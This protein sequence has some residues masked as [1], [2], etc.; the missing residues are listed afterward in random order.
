[1]DNMSSTDNCHDLW[2]QILT[3]IKAELSEQSF[4]TWFECVQC[5][6]YHDETIELAVPDKFYGEWLQ[7]HYREIIRSACYRVCNIKPEISYVVLPS[8]S[9]PVLAEE[10]PRQAIDFSAQK[11]PV[12]RS[13][14]L[15]QTTSLSQLNATYTF[16]DFVVGPGNRFAHAA[17]VSIAESPSRTYN[18]FFLYGPSGLGKTHLLQAVAHEIQRRFPN[19]KVHYTS[20]ETFTNAL[21]DSIHKRTTSDFRNRF[22]QLDVLLIDDIHFIAGKDSTQEEFFHTFNALYDAKKQIILS[23][24]RSPKEIPSLEGR[25]VS[26]FEWGLT[27]DIQPPDFETRVAILKKK[28]E[29]ENVAVP[30]DVLFYIAEHITKNIRELEGALI[31]VCAYATLTEKIITLESVRAI[32]QTS[33][34]EENTKIT[35]DLIQQMVAHTFGI[36]VIDLRSKKRTKSVAHPRQVAMYLA[37]E[38]T[39][40]SFPEIGHYFG[41]KGHATVVHA[42]NR[43]KRLI[44]KN[45]QSIDGIKEIEKKLFKPC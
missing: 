4:K 3:I 44:E 28:L 5:S 23:S 11:N 31:R 13:L 41:G 42:C 2:Q 19:K 22:R 39:N 24:D 36:S 37:R 20:S 45:D 34:K 43:I 1:M 12:P 29:R 40:H 30:N 8:L 16:D 15:A 18:P 38:H 35:I 26:R 9:Q 25:L 32:L 33:V 14:S 17:A 27:T 21:I 6:S 7:D 10:P